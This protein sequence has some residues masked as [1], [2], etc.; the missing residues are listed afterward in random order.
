[1]GHASAYFESTI[2][3]FEALLIGVDSLS[4][5]E[6]LSKIAEAYDT[7]KANTW[8]VLYSSANAQTI[9]AFDSTWEQLPFEGEWWVWRKKE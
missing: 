5:S 3:S 1:M 9:S 4:F 8:G 6:A 7:S 2:F